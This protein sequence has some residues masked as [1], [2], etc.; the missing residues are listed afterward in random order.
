MHLGLFILGTGHHVAGWRLPDAEAGA[1]N[2]PLITRITQA[3]ERAK[4]DLVFFADAF[5]TGP[6]AHPS[7]MVRL[8]PLTLLAALAAQATHIGLAATASTTYSDPYNLARAF[9]SITTSAVAG[10]RGMW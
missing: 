10:R 4:F 5:N 7:V 6:K 9:A 8:E 3:A 1:E 2:F